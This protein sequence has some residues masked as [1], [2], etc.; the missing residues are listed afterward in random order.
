M[1][2]FNWLSGRRGAVQVAA[3]L[4]WLTGRAKLAGIERQTAAA[5][6]GPDM[7]DAVFLVAHFQEC[8]DELNALATRAG[9]D[10]DRVLIVS[11]SALEGRAAERGPDASCHLLIIVA[12]RHP[13]PSHDDALLQF[14]RSLS[15][16]CR[17]IQ[18]ASL[19]DPL[20]MAFAGPWVEDVLRRL[21]MTEEQAIESWMVRRHIRMAQQQI[22]NRAIGDAAAASA[23]AWIERNCPNIA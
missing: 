21:G 11:S 9:F 1:G 20:L 14:A 10:R 15:C 19:E 6:A 12:E 7:P 16:R 2:F 13:L 22:A 5:L 17:F 3:D 8:L 18:H 23:K 4:I